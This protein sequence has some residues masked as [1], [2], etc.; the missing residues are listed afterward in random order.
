VVHSADSNNTIIDFITGKPLPNAGAEA[1]R[2]AVERLLVDVKGFEKE[3]IE[4]DAPIVLIMGSER[5]QSTVDLVVRVH[6]IPFM[7]IKCAP[8]ALV[9]REREAIAAA[10]LMQDYQ[11]PLAVASDG[12]NAIVW[13]T[14]SGKCLGEGLNAIPTR[15]RA[16]AI[17]DVAALVPLDET[18]RSR[19]QLIFKSYDSM[20]VHRSTD[21]PGK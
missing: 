1:N 18:R 11:I 20:N 16:L 4:V 10:R 17:F 21:L 14:V 5:Y 19:Q 12:K 6:G 9:S 7:I 3:Q 2:Q 8:G 13:D 15:V